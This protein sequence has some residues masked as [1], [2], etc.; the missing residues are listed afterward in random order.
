MYITSLAQL[1]QWSPDHGGQTAILNSATTLP[2]TKSPVSRG[3]TTWLGNVY[4]GGHC[5][6]RRVSNGQEAATM[7]N[8][9]TSRSC[10]MRDTISSRL[11]FQ[12]KQNQHL[13]DIGK[14]ASIP[15][16]CLQKQSPSCRH[17]A[18][19]ALVAH[20]ATPVPV[21]LYMHRCQ[22]SLMQK[23]KRQDG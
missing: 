14:P 16:D 3:C 11:S 17:T 13:Q 22:L 10:S 19:F 8:S 21:K 4:P 6:M 2:S 1:A 9:L 15:A 23:P 20:L 18:S 7:G 5:C 12:D